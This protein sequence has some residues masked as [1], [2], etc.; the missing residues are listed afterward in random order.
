MIHDRQNHDSLDS[1]R[2]LNFVLQILLRL[3]WSKLEQRSQQI[4]F[5]LILN[6]RLLHSE[7]FLCI[8]NMTI[9]LIYLYKMWGILFLKFQHKYNGTMTHSHHKQCNLDYLLNIAYIYHTSTLWH[10]IYSMWPIG[11]IM[12]K[13]LTTA[14]SEQLLVISDN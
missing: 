5:W 13:F 7:C 3:K 11:F 9:L 1:D 10:S 8:Q 14:S 12:Y 2:D 6:L 4:L